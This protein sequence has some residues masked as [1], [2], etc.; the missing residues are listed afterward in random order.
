MP[1][2]AA[3]SSKLCPSDI[4]EEVVSGQHHDVISDSIDRAIMSQK[5][6]AFPIVDIRR[7]NKRNYGVAL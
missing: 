5:Y 1:L 7:W 2:S 6:C 3:I 4:P